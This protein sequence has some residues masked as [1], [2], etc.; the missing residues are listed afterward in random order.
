ME[1]IMPLIKVSSKD[2]NS[3]HLRR[4]FGLIKAQNQ[5]QK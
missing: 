4:V 5:L 2:P 3:Q 1:N